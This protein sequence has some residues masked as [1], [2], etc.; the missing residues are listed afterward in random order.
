MKLLDKAREFENR[1]MSKL[2]TSDRVALS[3]EAKELILAIKEIYKKNQDPN[4][5][6]IMKS[7]TLKKRKIEKRLKGP[8]LV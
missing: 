7:L 3:R 4:L 1:K 2:S 6:D 5:M 8:L